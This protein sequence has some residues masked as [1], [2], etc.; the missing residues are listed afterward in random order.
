EVAPGMLWLR[1]PLPIALDHI[2]LW[3]VADGDGWTAIDT[4]FK[5]TKIRELW[6]QVAATHMGGKPIKR[7]IVT[8]MHP[9]HVGLAGWL[10][11]KYGA[12][13]WMTQTDWLY[14]RMLS[15]EL[16]KE[17]P[18]MVIE[19]YRRLG[20]TPAELEFFGSLGYNNFA[21]GV[22]PVPVGYRRIVDGEEITIG[23]HVFKVIVGRGHSPEHACLW[24]AKHH[25][26]VAG[27]MVLPRISPHIGVYVSEED[28]N[29]LRD[30]LE[31]LPKLAE[32]PAD[33]LVLPAHNEPFRGLH[34][35]IGEL[36]AHHVQ[37]IAAMLAACDKP[38][39]VV[40]IIPFLFRRELDMRNRFF[41]AG[42]ALAHINHALAEGRL[43][44]S[45]DA[46]G[47]YLF[48][49]AAGAEAAA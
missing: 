35:R 31:S 8:H 43:L 38:R 37:R 17:P 45:V 13:L 3:L 20:F 4:G 39:R 47:V 7:V 30:Y 29:P 41:A 36:D 32:L 26:L 10:C 15:M 33:T 34:A 2:N 14:A 23:E 48:R 22:T 21:R 11:E 1:M 44:R 28:A 24:N 16:A 5:N 27:D 19:F 42:E 9:D 25:L 46:D 40:D 12:E 49:R 18:A 6:D